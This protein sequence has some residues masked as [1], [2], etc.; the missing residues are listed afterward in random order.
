VDIRISSVLSHIIRSY[1]KN[2]L[3][4]IATEQTKATE[5]T[6]ATTDQLLDYFTPHQDA[7]NRYHASCMILNIHSDAPYLSVYN[8]HIRIGGI[9]FCEKNHHVKTK[10][11]VP[12]LTQLL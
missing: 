8:A 3:N 7:T 2:A 12:F 4:E 6:Q 9:F 11:M 1:N 5:K 10:S